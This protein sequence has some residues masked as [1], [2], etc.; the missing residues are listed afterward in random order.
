MKPLRI[1]HKRHTLTKTNLAFDNLKQTISSDKLE[2]KKTF[3]GN[4]IKFL[5][6]TILQ[7]KSNQLLI[8][9]HLSAEN[10]SLQNNLPS[11]FYGTNT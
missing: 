9:L 11:T 3:N 5:Y 10:I 8:T 6:F 2:V 7:D 1:L 4:Y